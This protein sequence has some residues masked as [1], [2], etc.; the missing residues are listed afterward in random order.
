M[1]YNTAQRVFIVK[2]YTKTPKVSQVQSA[3]RVNYKDKRAPSRR[4]ILYNNAKLDK[5]G[6]VVH[7]PLKKP[8]ISQKRLNAKNV[9]KLLIEENAALSIR[10]LSSAAK[11]SFGMTQRILRRDLKLKPCKA[12]IL[13]K[14]FENSKKRCNLVIENFGGH[15]E[16]K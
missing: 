6:A 13:K 11:I 14:V 10:K 1:K 3:Y 4:A 9:L 7:T 16:N 12:D 5:T 15:F 2:N 8:K